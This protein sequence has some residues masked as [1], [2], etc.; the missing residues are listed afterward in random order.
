MVTDA[1][2][3]RRLPRRAH[4][5]SLEVEDQAWFSPLAELVLALPSEIVH[6]T[7]AFLR[8]MV[9]RLGCNCINMPPMSRAW[10]SQYEVACGKQGDT[11]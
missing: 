6:V 7:R 11:H 1:G 2:A 9:T 3:E 4:A 10:L 5:R 8:P